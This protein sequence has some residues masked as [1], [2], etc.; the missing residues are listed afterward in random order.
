MLA[1]FHCKVN[2]SHSWKSGP[3]HVADLQ[4]CRKASTCLCIHRLLINLFCGGSTHQGIC[5]CRKVWQ[6][7][8]LGPRYAATAVQ[9]NSNQLEIIARLVTQGKLKAVI[10]RVL[11]LEQA[12]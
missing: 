10:D 2:M 8:G 12:R 9:P 4:T 3:L 7:L 11:P 6:T 1:F 5:L